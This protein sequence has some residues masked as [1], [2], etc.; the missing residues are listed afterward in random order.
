MRS[1]KEDRLQTQVEKLQ[2]LVDFY[3]EDWQAMIKQLEEA[4]ERAAYWHDQ[5]MNSVTGS[6]V[7]V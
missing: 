3:R 7:K 4:E 1:H 2:V 6:N 5:Y